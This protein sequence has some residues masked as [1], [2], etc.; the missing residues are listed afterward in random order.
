VNATA[1]KNAGAAYIYIS[2]VMLAL[3]LAAAAALH[4]AKSSLPVSLAQKNLSGLYEAAAAGNETVLILLNNAL[5]NQ[6][7][8]MHTIIAGCMDEN[9][10]CLIGGLYYTLAYSFSFGDG[11][12]IEIE[13]V[14]T[15]SGDAYAVESTAKNFAGNVTAGAVLTRSTNI[16]DGYSLK[17]VEL[18]KIGR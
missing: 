2:I 5:K 11:L 4:A 8:D 18:K 9:F 7:G 3:F 17:M 10:S 14:I 6:S 12:V 1:K 15:R 16:F 13:T